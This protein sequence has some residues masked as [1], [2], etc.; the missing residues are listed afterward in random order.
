MIQILVHNLILNT[1]KNTIEKL[2]ANYLRDVVEWLNSRP[3]TMNDNKTH[4]E[5][6]KEFANET[7]PDPNWY[8]Y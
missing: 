7:N 5:L 2:G 3:E 6:L 1:M 4:Q 8:N